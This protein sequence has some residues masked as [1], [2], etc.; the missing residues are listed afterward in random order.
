M[1]E[2]HLPVDRHV[3]GL[4]H[5]ADRLLRS[6]TAAGDGATVPTCPGWSVR[7]LLLHLGS[8]HRWAAAMLDGADPREVDIDTYTSGGEAAED[9][10]AWV[11]AGADDLVATLRRVP[12]DVA[13]FTFLKD[14][15]PPRLFWAR[16]QHHET[17]M[18]ALDAV[19]AAA[20]H[21]PTAADVWFDHTCAVDGID[22][23]LVGFW[24]RRTKGPRSSS[25]YAALVAADEGGRWLLD[26][27][28]DAVTTRRLA[29]DEPGP[30]GRVRLLTG[31]AVDLH[32][33]LW[34]RGGDPRDPTGL[35]DEWRTAGIT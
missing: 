12:D 8:V 19:A 25:P 9:L 20:Q 30:D 16:R 33:A 14:A 6:A 13:A 31:P 3:A 35:L 5:A 29:R 21:H 15:P 34:N 24:P 17:T 7:D 1:S 18:H 10:H 32:L 23:L 2:D 11:A 27:G 22:E 4:R 28:P 26:V